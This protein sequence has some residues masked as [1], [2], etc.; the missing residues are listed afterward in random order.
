MRKNVGF[1]SIVGQGIR[2]N[3]ER[4]SRML[5]PA[6]DDASIKFSGF[7]STPSGI[8]IVVFVD[9]NMVDDAIRAAHRALIG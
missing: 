5:F 1:I 9:S 2:E 4:V 8:S 6:L 3:R 7:T